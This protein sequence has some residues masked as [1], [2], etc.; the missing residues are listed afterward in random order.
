MQLREEEEEE[1]EE[2]NLVEGQGVRERRRLAAAARVVCVHVC[3]GVVCRFLCKEGKLSQS[4]VQQ[5]CS[6]MVVANIIQFTTH[7]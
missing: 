6:K 2:E 1:E 5:D 4:V 3:G 7:L